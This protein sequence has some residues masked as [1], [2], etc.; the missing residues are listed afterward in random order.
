MT[1]S[2][3]KTPLPLFEVLSNPPYKNT[4]PWDSI[5]FFWADERCVMPNRAESNYA[6]A[7]DNLLDNVYVKPENI[8]RI[9]GEMEPGF[10]AKM[11]IEELLLHRSVNYTWPEM[12]YVLLGMGVDGHTASL[13]PTK[14][15]LKIENNPV[16][17][18]KAVYQGRPA[19]RV[20]LTPI[21]FNTAR[22]IVFLVTGKSKAEVVA[23]ILNDNKNQYDLPVN[24]IQSIEGGITWF[25]DS[26]AGEFVDQELISRN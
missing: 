25:L 19:W 9:K 20:T 21:V 6:L 8:H 11:Y 18:V 14:K 12:D 26:S 4:I 2:G 3:G 22:N 16:A 23:K 7:K 13:F 1:L 15:T 10:A 17:V 24:W 5:H